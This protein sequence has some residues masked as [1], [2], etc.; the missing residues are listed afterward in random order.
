MREGRSCNRITHAY[1]LPGRSPD[2]PFIAQ[3]RTALLQ[4]TRLDGPADLAVEVISPESVQRDRET[5]FGE[6]ERGGVREFWLLDPIA[7]QA[8][9]FLLGEDGRYHSLPVGE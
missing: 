9:F 3:Q 5:R 4:R 7:R 1:H 2:L 6:Y 8:D